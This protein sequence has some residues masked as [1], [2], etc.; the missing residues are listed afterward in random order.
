MFYELVFEG[1]EHSAF[2]DR[3]LAGANT[4]NPKHH[5]AILAI[6]T[7]FWDTYL[8]DDKFAEEWLKGEGPSTMLDPPDIWQKK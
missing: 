1:G 7:A 5:P 3:Q 6:S 2:S 8:K 4:R